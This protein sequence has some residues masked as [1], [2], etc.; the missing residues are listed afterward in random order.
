MTTSNTANPRKGEIWL[1]DF[2]P[3]RGAEISKQ[4]PAV[5]ISEDS[6]GKLPLKIIV[7][8]T[9]WKSGYASYPWFTKITPNTKNK[10][11]KESGADGFQ[12]KSISH[13]RFKHKIGR[14]PAKQLSNIL[15]T[16]AVCI[17]I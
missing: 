6:I 8:I 10:L 12:V 3:V 13:D 16:V 4:R 14:I 9:D 1:V 5:V 11:N 15:A 2:N 17:G 7:P